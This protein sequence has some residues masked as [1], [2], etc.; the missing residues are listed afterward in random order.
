MDPPSLDPYQVLCIDPK[1]AWSLDTVRRNYKRLAL[2]LHP[3]KCRLDSEA[4]TQVFQVLTTAYRELVSLE[5]S[6]RADKTF[7]ELKAEY[8]DSNLPAAGLGGLGGLGGL[9][10]VPSDKDAFDVAKFNALFS[11]HRVERPEDAGY[12]EWMK[13]SLSRQETTSRVLVR[14]REPEAVAYVRRHGVEFH[15][16]GTG[17]VDDYSKPP[18][19]D[20]SVM[21]TDYKVA[22][23]TGRLIDPDEAMARR[24]TYRN[25]KELEKERAQVRFVM[26][27][28][29]LLEQQKAA[30][31][32]DARE[33]QRLQRLHDEDRML[34][35]HYARVNR[36]FVEGAGGR[37]AG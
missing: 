32:R 10:G 27:K 11:E 25:V 19:C 5:A 23:T 7:V 9:A 26:N 17:V 21:Y 15:E 24:R 37:H 36:L 20:R 18:S 31:L 35:Q 30:A 12:H 2:Q 29:E 4:A 6:R 3:D 8:S 13:T 22:H 16:L 33:A 14:H 1:S 28:R 34:A